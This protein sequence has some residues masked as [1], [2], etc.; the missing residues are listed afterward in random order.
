MYCCNNRVL[1]CLIGRESNSF[2]V[3][4]DSELEKCQASLMRLQMLQFMLEFNLKLH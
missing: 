2:A 3:Q 1:T 4:E